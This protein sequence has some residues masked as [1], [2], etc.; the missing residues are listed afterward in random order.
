MHAGVEGIALVLDF[1]QAPSQCLVAFLDQG[2]QGGI[3]SEVDFFTVIAGCHIT[4]L[5]TMFHVHQARISGQ[6]RHL[7]DVGCADGVHEGGLAAF[8]RAKDNKIGLLLLH[9][10]E[11]TLQTMVHVRKP[12]NRPL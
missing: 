2:L 11:Q 5:V 3:V 8:K 4:A 9:L 6:R 1:A 10:V 12:R 7:A